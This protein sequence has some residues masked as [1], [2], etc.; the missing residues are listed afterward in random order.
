MLERVIET[1]AHSVEI[2]W[3]KYINRSESLNSLRIGRTISI[4]L[5]WKYIILQDW[6]Q[7]SEKWLRKLNSYY[8]LIKFKKSL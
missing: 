4:L 6:F 7:I 8:S 1:F 2:I 5:N 3:S